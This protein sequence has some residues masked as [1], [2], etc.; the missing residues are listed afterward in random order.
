MM[1][2]LKLCFI[3]WQLNLKCKQAYNERNTL[4]LQNSEQ[5]DHG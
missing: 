2:S 1:I 4:F 3:Y 5:K